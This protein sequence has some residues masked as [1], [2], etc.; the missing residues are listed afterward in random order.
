[1]VNQCVACGAEMPEGDHV[2]KLCRERAEFDRCCNENLADR[3]EELD[4]DPGVIG[5]NI[6]RIM[7]QEQISFGLL[8]E[9]LGVHINTVRNWTE[10]G[11]CPRAD[12]LYAVS[13]VLKRPMEDFFK[14]EGA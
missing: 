7:K 8:A 1:M 13:K 3:I 14:E 11:R 5:R 10:E 9:W 4:A 2:C 12:K 6:R